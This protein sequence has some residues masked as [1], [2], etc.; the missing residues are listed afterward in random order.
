[1]KQLLSVMA[2]AM[3]LVFS[4]GAIVYSGDPPSSP[5]DDKDKDKKGPGKLFSSDPK[6]EKKD[7]KGGK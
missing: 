1:M 5:T 7:D 2:L 3:A 4:S 6:D